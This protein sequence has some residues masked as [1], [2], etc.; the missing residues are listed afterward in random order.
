MPLSLSQHFPDSNT[1]RPEL[2]ISSLQQKF[3][4]IMSPSRNGFFLLNISSWPPGGKS[5]KGRTAFKSNMLADKVEGQHMPGPNF[6]THTPGEPERNGLLF[7][8]S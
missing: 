1:V 2:H 7:H 8:S 5:V 4:V 3:K 6:N